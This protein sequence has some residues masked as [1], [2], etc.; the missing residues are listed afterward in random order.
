M[1]TLQRTS[2]PALALIVAAMLATGFTVAPAHALTPIP[3][4]PTQEFRAP[5]TRE[6]I[7]EPHTSNDPSDYD[8]GGF[9]APVASGASQYSGDSDGGL[10]LKTILLVGG[11]FVSLTSLV[12]WF[13]RT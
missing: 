12:M 4:P 3:H 8:T 10:D 11:A 5:S 13:R 2:K 9:G 6:F 7:P 1:T